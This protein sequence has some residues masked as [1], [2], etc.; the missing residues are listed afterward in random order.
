M[1]AALTAL[2]LSGVAIAVWL[3]HSA[4]W[5]ATFV[6]QRLTGGRV[7]SVIVWRQP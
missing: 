3:L 6:R 5:R 2:V 1:T 7:L 4:G